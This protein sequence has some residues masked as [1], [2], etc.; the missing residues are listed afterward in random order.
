MAEET[1]ASAFGG[2]PV[3]EGHQM[4]QQQESSLKTEETK[5][6]EAP[7]QE[8]PA[9]ETKKEESTPPAEKP[10]EVDF[11]TLLKEKSGGN[12]LV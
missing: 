1:L 3:G 10:K 2:K 6:T 9:A 7:K 5:T 8:A 11:N 12:M 4:Q